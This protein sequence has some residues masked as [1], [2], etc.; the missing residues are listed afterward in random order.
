MIPK[1]KAPQD[2]DKSLLK[3]LWPQ[4]PFILVLGTSHSHGA[5]TPPG[6]VEHVLEDHEKWVGLMQAHLGIRVL[7]LSQPGTINVQM[8]QI[9]NDAFDLG[10]E[11]CKA[12][13]AEPRYGV[14]GSMVCMD[15]FNDYPFFPKK[16]EEKL[17]P[18]II[19]TTHYG[20]RNTTGSRLFT[21]YAGG[22][23][24]DPGY[25]KRIISHA[26]KDDDAI[27]NKAVEDI[28]RYTEERSNF[29]HRSQ[30]A[31]WD[32]AMEIRNWITLCRTAKI[33]FKWFHWSKCKP[34]LD[35]NGVYIPWKDGST[36]TPID[37]HIN[38]YTDVFK[39]N[40]LAYGDKI[41]LN[42][43]LYGQ[44]GWTVDESY[45]CGGCGHYNAEGNKIIWEEVLKIR[46]DRWL[47]NKL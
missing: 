13:I 32:D 25:F 17:G 14:G 35:Y 47:K 10:M 11:N 22:K 19:G 9:L 15:N 29:Y 24:N 37:D 16:F 30:H 31:E 8:T 21:T 38:E 5:C 28:K 4:E 46:I 40:L 45:L 3:E 34:L 2:F 6:D 33:P 43:I 18:E 36:A 20:Q 39:T 12:V 7:N 42:N 44:L 1:K 26:F 41:G 23:V 27:P